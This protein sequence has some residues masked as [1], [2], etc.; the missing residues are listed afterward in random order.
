MNPMVVILS[1]THSIHTQT[2]STDQQIFQARRVLLPFPF[3]WLISTESRTTLPS[4]TSTRPHINRLLLVE[5]GIYQTFGK[6][7]YRKLIGNTEFGRILL[8]TENI[9]LWVL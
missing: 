6:T 7:E 5:H 9:A 4:L 8:E 1:S 2:F 3:L